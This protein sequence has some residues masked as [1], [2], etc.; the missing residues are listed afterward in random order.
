M[1]KKFKSYDVLSGLLVARAPWTG[2]PDM[3]VRL[4]TIADMEVAHLLN[5][6]RRSAVW[7]A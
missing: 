3:G 1:G 4:L 2:G 5:P 6:E 7:C